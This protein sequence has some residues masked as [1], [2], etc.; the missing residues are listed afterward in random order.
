[1]QFDYRFP[2]KL[3]R[4]VIAFCLWEE[5]DTSSQDS[6]RQTNKKKDHWF[7]LPE[8]GVTQQSVPIKLAAH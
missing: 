2:Q 1:M 3:R 8:K 6:Q 4:Y 7:I 5:I